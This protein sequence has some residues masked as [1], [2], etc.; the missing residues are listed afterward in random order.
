MCWCEKFFH[1][2]E[3]KSL[4]DWSHSWPN[5]VKGPPPPPPSF[6]SFGEDLIIFEIL[7]L[8]PVLV[9]CVH[10]VSTDISTV[11]KKKKKSPDTVVYFSRIQW[12]CEK[13][14][15]ICKRGGAVLRCSKKKSQTL[16]YK[17]VAVRFWIK[18]SWQ[19]K[20]APHFHTTI[21]KKKNNDIKARAGMFRVGLPV[22][23]PWCLWICQ[24]KG[25]NYEAQVMCARTR[26]KWRLA[27][28]ISL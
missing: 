13:P 3:Q 5:K 8:P 27:S 24:Q 12:W 10:L 4:R 22:S 17:S 11:K 23:L 7:R 9:E 21:K 18:V 20:D 6:P 26:T 19:G 28:H 1:L 25:F 15:V 16:E 14:P 2:F